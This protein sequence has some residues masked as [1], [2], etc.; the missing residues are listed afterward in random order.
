MSFF[1][2][3]LIFKYKKEFDYKLNREVYYPA[4]GIILKEGDTQFETTAIID[5]G[6]DTFFISQEV[7]DI[8]NLKLGKEEIADVLGGGNIKVRASN[9]NVIFVRGKNR[10]DMGN[11]PVSV[12][13]GIMGKES[14]MDIVIG[15]NPIF[16]TLK[17]TFEQYKKIVTIEKLNPKWYK[18]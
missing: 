13:V 2:K 11:I 12:G 17:I 16:N 3:K 8:L 15:R 4:I 9:L 1:G 10:I 14:S 5:S 7:A 18:Y 6:S